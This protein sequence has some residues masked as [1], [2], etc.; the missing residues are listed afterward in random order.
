MIKVEENLMKRTVMLIMFLLLVGCSVNPKKIS[1]HTMRF[2]KA[3][4]RANQE[5]LLLNIVR[6]SKGIAPVYTT[7]TINTEKINPSYMSA[8]TT[9]FGGDADD[10]FILNTSASYAVGPTVTMT[11]LDTQEFNRGISQPISAQTIRNY[12][13][14]GWK[15]NLLLPILV[16][17]IKFD[18]P[19]NVETVSCFESD[20]PEQGYKLTLEDTRKYFNDPYLQGKFHD[21]LEFIEY[22]GPED[23]IPV[24]FPDEGKFGPTYNK[25]EFSFGDLVKLTDESK[26]SLVPVNGN[27]PLSE[28]KKF[29]LKKGNGL[30]KF[31]LDCDINYTDNELNKSG[32]ERIFF[33]TFDSYSEQLQDVEKQN[34]SKNKKP[35]VIVILRSTAG[36][37][38]YLG[39]LTK[40][41]KDYKHKPNPSSDESKLYQ[42]VNK[43]FPIA[44]EEEDNRNTLVH[45]K[46][47][48]DKYYILEPD[49]ETSQ[50]DE[51]IS[52]SMKI[53][54][55]LSQILGLHKS[56][57]DLPTTGTV[58][59][60]A[61]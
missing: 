1:D 2:N 10:N 59:L 23:I 50:S 60:I 43:L 17:Y 53:I 38:E 9:P 41:Q 57:E 12:W 14:R 4:E 29:Q 26:L 61:Q 32:I 34:D 3:V 16:E 45:V 42:E 58:N 7:I 40:V 24:T 56:R 48:E 18:I 49:E 15:P 55:F 11:N 47:N 5:M 33:S 13:E 37:I 35:T 44:F 28:V 8:L 54:S 31:S 21:Y 39:K 30:T 51:G 25:G 22:I 52:Q 6:E 46:H 27:I 36:I 19:A 20:D